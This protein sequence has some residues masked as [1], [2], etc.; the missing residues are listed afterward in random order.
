M[1]AGGAPSKASQMPATL[2]ATVQDRIGA[3]ILIVRHFIHP[4]PLCQS[5]IHCVSRASYSA[6]ASAQEFDRFS[7][8]TGASDTAGAGAF[9]EPVPCQ[10]LPLS[11]LR[12]IVLRDRTR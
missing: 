3:G 12:Y 7:A 4:D 10:A 9:T 11:V 8:A 5:E 2:F 1:S 6:S